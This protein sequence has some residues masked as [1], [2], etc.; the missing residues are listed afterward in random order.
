MAFGAQFLRTSRL[1]C[2]WTCGLPF[3]QYHARQFLDLVESVRRP[4][5]GLPSKLMVF[6]RRL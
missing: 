6:N 4:Y 3:T 2:I 1:S 5:Y